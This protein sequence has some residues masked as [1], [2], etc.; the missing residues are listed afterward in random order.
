[1]A[2]PGAAAPKRRVTPAR[3]VLTLYGDYWWGTAQALPTAAIL[4]ALQTLGIKEPAGRAALRRLVALELLELERDGRRTLHRLTPRGSEII[5]E[6]A[7]WLDTFGVDET[8]WDGLWTVVAFSVPETSRDIRHSSRTRLRRLGFGPL[9]DG[10]WVSAQD[11]AASARAELASLGVADVTVMRAR[12][13]AESGRAPTSAWDLD[14]IA[15]RYREVAAALD[16]VTADDEADA[17]RIRSDLMLDW[18]SMRE[19]DPSIPVELLPAD[20]PRVGVRRRFAERFNALE[21]AASARMR[22]LIAAVD[23]DL[24]EGLAPRLLR[25]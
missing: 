2:E 25:P 20:W 24:S 8:P 3:K 5:A 21:P 17:L 23:P 18:Q 7:H 9:Y 14:A 22:G 6:E 1:M 4:G 19:I 12:I 15:A 13:G 11:A 16:D 10:V